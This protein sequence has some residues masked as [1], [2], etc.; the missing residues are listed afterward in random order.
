MFLRGT[1]LDPTLAGMIARLFGAKLSSGAHL[2]QPIGR[3]YRPVVDVNVGIG[4]AE[5]QSV[6]F[7]IPV[8]QLLLSQRPPVDS[9][10]AP[11]RR[12]QNDLVAGLVKMVQGG[13]GRHIGYGRL[14]V[15]VRIAAERAVNVEAIDH[16][17]CIH[18]TWRWGSS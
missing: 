5:Q 6:V 14:V 7:D 3:I 2:K 4:L 16:G 12:E 13:D 9:S 17:H 15:A 1:P 11:S 10:G 8:P 18:A